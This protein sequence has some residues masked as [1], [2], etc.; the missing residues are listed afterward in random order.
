M[1]EIEGVRSFAVHA[2]AATTYLMMNKRDLILALASVTLLAAA[3]PASAQ[4]PPCLNDVE[5]QQAVQTGQILPLSEVLA[6]AGLPTDA[7]ILPPVR[8][9]PDATGLA[10]HVAVL[11]GQ[12]ARTLIL[13]AT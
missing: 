2:Q 13:P 3:S 10:Y 9:C 5:V 7:K 8:V 11:D 4:I 12:E 1:P 6:R